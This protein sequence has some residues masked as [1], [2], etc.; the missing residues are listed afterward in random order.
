MLL[1]IIAKHLLKMFDSEKLKM[2]ILIEADESLNQFNL[3]FSKLFIIKLL[4]KHVCRCITCQFEIE[5]TLKKEIIDNV[6]KNK[7]AEI[8]QDVVQSLIVKFSKQHEAMIKSEAIKKTKHQ[9]N[10]D[11]KRKIEVT[12]RV[13]VKHQICVSV[14]TSVRQKKKKLE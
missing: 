13:V 10:I 8:E 14:T 11:V 3:I 6:K 4:Q 7:Q 9:I 2:L 5:T 1:L 12:R